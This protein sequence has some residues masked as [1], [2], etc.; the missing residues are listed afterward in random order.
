M[1]KPRGIGGV[2]G[3]LVMV[4]NV[5]NLDEASIIGDSWREV[6]HPVQKKA[7][8]DSSKHSNRWNHDVLA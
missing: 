4:L 5:M 2:G 3:K 6:A 7:G 8:G 1:R